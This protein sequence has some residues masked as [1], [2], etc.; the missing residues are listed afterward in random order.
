M[1][2]GPSGGDDSG[3]IIIS[4]SRRTHSMNLRSSDRSTDT[5]IFEETLSVRISINIRKTVSFQPKFSKKTTF[6]KN[7]IFEMPT[8]L[9]K[10]SFESFTS[11]IQ[12]IIKTETIDTGID[13]EYVL[14]ANC[15][16]HGTPFYVRSSKPT[17]LDTKAWG[18]SLLDPLMCVMNINDFRKSIKNVCYK[19]VD[20]NLVLDVWVCIK[21]KKEASTKSARS[22]K[23][24]SVA[25][26]EVEASDDHATTSFEISIYPP[27]NKSS[28]SLYKLDIPP[29]K[30][31]SLKDIC[32]EA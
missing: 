25:P 4:G 30:T 23:E 12:D 8:T 14:T 16:N 10:L 17:S 29:W 3:I 2:P 5:D 1:T 32:L 27:L 15:P 20:G 21:E 28:E 24:S 19:Q 11:G 31:T 26:E 13:T 9:Q 18:E 6:L 22:K 7:K